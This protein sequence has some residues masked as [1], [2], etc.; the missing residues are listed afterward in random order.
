MPNSSTGLI[1]YVFTR[2]NLL[3]QILGDCPW[4][5]DR[6]RVEAVDHKCLHRDGLIRAL[7]GV[8]IEPRLFPVLVVAELAHFL[9]PPAIGAPHLVDDVAGDPAQDLVLQWEEI[10]GQTAIP[11]T[12]TRQSDSRKN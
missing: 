10:W 4:D 9:S 7:E 3:P 6:P 5:F 12:I 8:H 2:I 11:L 1:E